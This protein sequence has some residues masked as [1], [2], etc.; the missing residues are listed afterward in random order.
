[1]EIIHGHPYLHEKLDFLPEERPVAYQ[2]STMIR[3]TVSCCVAPARTQTRY[4]RCQ[5][6]CSAKTV[7]GRGAGAGL[8]REPGKIA[9][10]FQTL[11]H[12]LGIPVT[13]K[14]RLGWDEDS[15]NFHQVARF[16][17]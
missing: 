1:M 17:R 7:S 6:G 5:P 4:H 14:I 15:R 3:K 16:W 12:A 11:T 13:A 8:L 2:Y 10:I 9:A